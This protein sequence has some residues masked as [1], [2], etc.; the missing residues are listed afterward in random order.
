MRLGD[1]ERARRM[2][3]LTSGLELKLNFLSNTVLPADLALLHTH[4]C[5]PARQPVLSLAG[6]SPRFQQR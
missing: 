2:K 4:A 6:Q 1:P 3:S 5:A